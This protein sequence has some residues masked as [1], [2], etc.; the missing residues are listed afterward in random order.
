MEEASGDP[1]AEDMIRDLTADQEIIAKLSR[2]V[3][4]TA[5][6]LGDE[7]SAGIATDRQVIHEKNAWMLRS[8]LE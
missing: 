1:N 5:G 7:A 3:V 4:A 2:E 6:Q 8:H